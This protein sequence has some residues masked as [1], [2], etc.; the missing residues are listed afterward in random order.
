MHVRT[1]A[2]AVSLAA[3]CTPRTVYAQFTDPRT[4][5]NAPVD[6]SQIEADYTYAHSDA[7]IDTALVVSGASFD[8]NKATLAYTRTFGLL[9]RMAWVK[10]AV[11]L[12][13]V[14]GSVAGTSFSRSVSGAGDASIEMAMLLRGGPALSATNFAAYQPTTTVALSLTVTGPTGEYDPN[15]LLNLGSHRWA[16]RPEFAV[17]HPFGPDDKWEIDGYINIEFYT[18]NTEY[19]GTEVLR[20]EPLPGVEG[21]LSCSIAPDF[22]A[23]ADVRYAFRGTTIV[24]GANQQDAQSQMT[25]GIELNWALSSRNSLGFVAATS[26]VHKN[27]PAYSGV[28]LKYFYSF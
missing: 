12:A 9:E 27:A 11:P 15:K 24:D 22:W 5:T 19:H 23:S 18:D 7:S 1:L 10:A 20:Q 14:K 28:V 25:L 21:H 17:S 13:S 26:P 8:L 2:V 4:Y 6:A 3:V 16:F